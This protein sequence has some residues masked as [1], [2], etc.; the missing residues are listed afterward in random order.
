M[1]IAPSILNANFGQLQTEIDSIKT[2]NRIHLDI[3]DGHYVPNLTIGAN[4]LQSVDFGDIPLEVHLMVNEPEKFFYDFVELG[5][6]GITFH[7]EN[8]GVAK[9]KE[10]LVDLKACGIAAGI[11]IDGYTSSEFLTDE[12]L[13]LADQ[14]L[15]MSVKAG[16]GGQP[17]MME[18]LAK[19]KSL[20][21][22]GYKKEIEIDG[23]AKL[24]NMAAIKAAGCDIAV[25]GSYLMKSQ[26]SERQ[27]R[28][29]A[30]QAI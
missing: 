28:L 4:L 13:D 30:L 6:M 19:I 22:R 9:A 8:T 16:A 10:L 18:S 1:L 17:F 26:D 11:C 23:G 15:V 12:I 29:K 21:A 24:D 25:V 2:A 14:I 7:I 3:M 27:E 20:R 5:V